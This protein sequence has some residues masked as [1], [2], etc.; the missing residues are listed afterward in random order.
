MARTKK[1]AAEV[2]EKAASTTEEVKIVPE[3]IENVDKTEEDK[4]V[5]AIKQGM[6]MPIISQA[7]SK[8]NN[9]D[10]N[11]NV[12]CVSLVNGG[13]TFISPK[14]GARS[15]WRDRGSHVTLTFGEL[16]E[17][18]NIKIAYLTTPLI[19]IDNKDVIDY[20]KLWPV[21]EK[22]AKVNEVESV[23]ESGDLNK[24]AL[25]VEDCLA[26]NMRNALIDKVSEMRKNN[27][28]TNINIIQFLEEKLDM[29]FS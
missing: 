26:V 14:N 21:Y 15:H 27:A 10:I 28:L 25:L 29:D 9:I 5:D 11:L 19:Y 20:F 1:T 24:I 2:V 22:V 13:L 3:S 23:I 16:I 8:L 17:L 4:I 7:E 12:R 6:A 18:N